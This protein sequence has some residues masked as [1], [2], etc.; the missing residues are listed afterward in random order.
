MFRL[1][2]DRAIKTFQNLLYID[3]SFK[4]ANLVHIRL[5]LMFKVTKEFDSSIKVS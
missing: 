5:G 2:V 1:I 4:C 3:P